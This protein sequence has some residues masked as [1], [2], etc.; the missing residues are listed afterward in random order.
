MNSSVNNNKKK[1]YDGD[2]NERWLKGAKKGIR[3][4]Y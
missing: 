4:K 3:R 1:S 2:V